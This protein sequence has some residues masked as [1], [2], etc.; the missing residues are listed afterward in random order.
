M[1]LKAY[2]EVIIRTLRRTC[3]NIIAIKCKAEV[4]TCPYSDF[5]LCF[6]WLNFWS[7]CF[8]SGPSYSPQ[9][10]SHNHSSLHSSNSHSNPSKTSDT[11][12][13]AFTVKS[14]LMSNFVL[15]MAF[16]A[17]LHM[18]FLPHVSS[19]VLYRVFIL[20]FTVFYMLMSPITF[21]CESTNL[22][23]KIQTKCWNWTQTPVTILWNNLKLF[24]SYAFLHT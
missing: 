10:N 13:V 19:A 21:W 17:R 15:T 3:L 22:L 20:F 16:A 6:R 12:S 4:T 5:C 2:F 11:V 9:E 7:V 23:C 18:N 8:V 24:L 1:D 14:V